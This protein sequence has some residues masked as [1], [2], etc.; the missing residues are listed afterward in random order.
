MKSFTFI[1]ERSE[2]KYLFAVVVLSITMVF[3][4]KAQFSVSLSSEQDFPYNPPPII[5]GNPVNYIYEYSVSGNFPASS[6]PSAGVC[7]ISVGL[8]ANDSCMAG[9]SASNV[10]GQFV[11][12]SPPEPGEQIDFVDNYYGGQVQGNITVDSSYPLPENLTWSISEL[13]YGGDSD[14]P[15][16][17][18][19]DTYAGVVLVPEPGSTG[20][21]FG[22]VVAL[23]GFAVVGLRKIPLK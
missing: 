6:D 15:S 22:S 4:G 2:L 5:N 13:A 20:L 8:G 9:F 14:D 7:A 11:N 23:A 19:L 18:V 10:G 12:N 3:S 17:D 16:L 1:C 21:L